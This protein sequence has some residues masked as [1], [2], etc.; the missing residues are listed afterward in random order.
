[1]KAK[2]L[3]EKTDQE[4]GVELANSL[5]EYQNLKFKKVVGVVD[6][7]LRV[8]LLKRD[9]SRFKTILH[10]RELDKIKKEI[11]KTE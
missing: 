1:M 9:I 8:R 6:N 4:L 11:G 2:E 7:P 10:E 5:K 3:R